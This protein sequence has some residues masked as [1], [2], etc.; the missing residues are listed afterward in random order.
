MAWIILLQDD[1]DFILF[2]VCW[3]RAAHYVH[4]GI[5]WTGN[6]FKVGCHLGQVGQ[7][8]LLPITVTRLLP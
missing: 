7:L 6:I 5:E 8:A 1:A 4:R 2:L 3:R